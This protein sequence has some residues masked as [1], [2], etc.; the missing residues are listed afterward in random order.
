MRVKCIG[1]QGPEAQAWAELLEQEDELLIRNRLAQFSNLQV[2]V[3][4]TIRTGNEITLRTV[5]GN[6]I[7]FEK[8]PD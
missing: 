8:L 1:L 6:Q 2:A 5:F 4:R 3:V 7:T